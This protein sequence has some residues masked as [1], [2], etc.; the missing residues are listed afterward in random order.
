M[1]TFRKNLCLCLKPFTQGINLTLSSYVDLWDSLF[2]KV[3]MATVPG[4]DA[5]SLPAEQTQFQ[6]SSLICSHFFL[7]MRCF[8]WMF[9]SINRCLSLLTKP[10]Q[11]GFSKKYFEM[12]VP[13]FKQCSLFTMSCISLI[14]FRL[15]HYISLQI[16][17][18]FAISLCCILYVLSIKYTYVYLCSFFFLFSLVFWFCFVL[19]LLVYFLWAK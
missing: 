9:F 10:T 4:V 8:Q 11:L 2:L 15:T 7:E 5:R 14:F 19:F 6:P 17:Q 1:P 3:L 18:K 13:E 12:L 16:Q